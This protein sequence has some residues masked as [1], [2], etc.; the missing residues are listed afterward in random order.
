ML[1]Q[2]CKLDAP[3]YPDGA[4]TSSGTGTNTGTNTGTGTGTGTV[5]SDDNGLSIGP[6]NTVLF[7]LEGGAITTMSNPS[8]AVQMDGEDPSYP[9]GYTQIN[10]L[11][12]LAGL[13]FRIEF[14]SAH[15]G[16]FTIHGINI[17]ARAYNI[18]NLDVGTVKVTRFDASNNNGITHGII[19]GQF[20]GQQV[21]MTDNALVNVKGSFKINI[22]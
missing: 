20:T 3:V 19:T 22:P 9:N 6:E 10:A 14:K 16:T 17:N 2:G 15:A 4:A 7:Q 13:T 5:T 21:R 1:I 18:S 11:D 12:V 8:L